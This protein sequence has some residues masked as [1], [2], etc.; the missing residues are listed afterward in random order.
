MTVFLIGLWGCSSSPI[1]PVDEAVQP[2]AALGRGATVVVGAEGENPIALGAVV[3]VTHESAI[4]MAAVRGDVPPPF[5]V[6]L[7]GDTPVAARI[8][9]RGEGVLLLAVPRAGRDLRPLELAPDAPS[10]LAEARF[11]SPRSAGRAPVPCAIAADPPAGSARVAGVAWLAGAPPMS[12]D[13]ERPPEARAADAEGGLVFDRQGRLLGLVGP[14]DKGAP[15][16]LV[17]SSVALRLQE[18]IL[19][20]PGADLLRPDDTLLCYSVK[21]ESLSD[22]PRLGDEET[23][24]PMLVLE[25]RVADELVG[26]I[27]VTPGRP[28]ADVLVSARAIGPLSLQ[29]T[30]LDRNLA[31]GETRAELS[32][33]AS[34]FAI[35]PRLEAQLEL[36]PEVLARY[37]GPVARGG[38]VRARLAFEPVDPD[39]EGGLRHTPLLPTAVSPGRPV[40]TVLDLP[41]GRATEF[42][43]I[44]DS[45]SEDVIAL[46]Y[47]RRL[48]GRVAFTIFAP[49]YESDLVSIVAKD[50]GPHLAVATGRLLKGR[51][52]ARLRQLSGDAAV[53]CEVLVA[54]RSD[55]SEV[56][57]PLFRLVNR[58][59]AKAGT[60]F[61]DSDAFVE[62][63]AEALEKTGL[64]HEALCRALLDELGGRVQVSRRLAFCL[65]ERHFIPPRALLEE[66]F[67]AGG[68]AGAAA[69]DA[70]LILAELDPRE[71]KVRPVLRHAC[72][73]FDPYVRARAVRAA[74]RGGDPAFMEEIAALCEKDTAPI[75][76]RAVAAAKLNAALLRQAEKH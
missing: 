64:P 68:G 20:V 3:R 59:A 63:V 39:R 41:G 72:A 53:P 48:G 11:L 15:R 26:R 74:S 57:G 52:I 71:P 14:P 65:L 66:A 46:L 7:P 25:V 17:S 51:V 45:A 60:A 16:L 29:L 27:E 58:E 19:S 70:G 34:F 43:T 1:A 37:T 9:A 40:E 62:E 76:E 38:T 31:Q 61:M 12:D 24:G 55:A 49:G 32:K 22:L 69:H 75:V 2:P 23:S 54:A 6:K 21:V 73:D 10:P 44:T 36:D 50:R 8:L 4:V 30:A 18:S 5:R 42:F 47:R 13:D 56:V 28:R 35:V 33:P 67:A